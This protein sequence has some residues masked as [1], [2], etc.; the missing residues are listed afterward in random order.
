MVVSGRKSAQRDETKKTKQKQ[1]PWSKRRARGIPVIMI[2]D[3]EYKLQ[4]WA[5]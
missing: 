3:Q 4:N 5:T 1:Q 2:A